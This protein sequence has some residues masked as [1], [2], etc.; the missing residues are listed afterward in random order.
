MA[1]HVLDTGLL[2]RHLRGRKPAVRLL[3]ELGRQDRLSISAVT[4]AEIRAGMRQPEDRATQ[5]LLARLDTVPVSADVADLA[6][7]LVRRARGQGRTLHVLDALIGAT[8][9]QLGVTLI[10]LN[11]TD[12]QGL[13]L[14]LYPLPDDLV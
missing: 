12:F 2:I 14:R 10:T 3:R 1:G 11:L 9:V 13:G 6:G 8:A 4:R 5:R 7:D